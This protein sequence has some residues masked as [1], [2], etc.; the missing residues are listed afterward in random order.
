MKSSSVKRTFIIRTITAMVIIF[1]SVSA[2][3]TYAYAQKYVSDVERDIKY[4]LEHIT[5]DITKDKIT[6]KNSSEYNRRQYAEF[7]DSVI[8][9]YREKGLDDIKSEG[10]SIDIGLYFVEKDTLGNETGFHEV[11]SENDSKDRIKPTEF[12]RRCEENNRVLLKDGVSVYTST[13]AVNDSFLLTDASFEIS[14]II[15]DTD[16]VLKAYAVTFPVKYAIS[17]LN[18]FYLCVLLM[19]I[20][21]SIILI[22]GHNAIIERRLETE[23]KRRYMMDSMAHEMKTPLSVIK[24]F[25]ELLLEESNHDKRNR[26]ANSIISEADS[27]NSIIISMLDFSKM[28]AGTYPME[29]SSL[30]VGE[31]AE[32]Q[33][34]HAKILI[35]R[36]KLDLEV[37]IQSTPMILA[38]EKLVNNIISNFISNAV[39]HSAAGGKI[40][41]EV[42]G[43]NKEIYIGVYNQGMQIPPKEMEKLW[44]SFYRNRATNEESSGLGLAIVRNACLMH[45]G[46]YGCQ[47]EED[48][49]TFWAKIKSMEDDI[50]M[51][52]VSTG[53]VIGV[54]GPVYRLNHI[55]N[56]AAGILI[57]LLSFGNVWGTLAGIIFIGFGSYNLFKNGFYSRKTF[58][59]AAVMTVLILAVQWLKFFERMIDYPEMFVSVNVILL[60]MIFTV[61]LQT[62]NGLIDIGVSLKDI[63]KLSKL[64]Y[65]RLILGIVFGIVMIFILL[66]ILASA[67][68]LWWKW[69][70]ILIR[71]GIVFIA[72]YNTATMAQGYKWFNRKTKV[73]A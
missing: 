68:D 64:K 51:K 55:L 30:S 58:A 18:K 9:Y 40:G 16:Y 45:N 25:G 70:Y 54:T 12:R 24:G 41:I 11:V 35:D 37:K 60:C 29:L 6:D 63:N 32:N 3:A 65:R 8:Q 26:F 43:D 5:Y 2:V 47:N 52:E 67:T 31:L 34:E 49:V 48:G 39:S 61:I 22:S 38:D 72:V 17:T 71:C 53:P 14:Q 36:K 10:V 57:E 66:Y 62:L 23:K 73:S 7:A 15:S 59:L 50:E 69:Y 56:V 28:E 21:V 20:L 4:E 19:M 44:E 46:S 13:S 27:M 42:K 33:L 1:I